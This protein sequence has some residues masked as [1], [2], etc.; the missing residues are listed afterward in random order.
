[1]GGF[2]LFT[3]LFSTPFIPYSGRLTW[4]S[5]QPPQEQRCPFLAVRV[6]FSCVQ[7]KVWLPL[8]GIFIVCRDV[9]ACDYTRGFYGHRKRVCTES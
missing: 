6:V 2:I 5:L 9:N 7:T 4:V 1:M 8:L 3:C